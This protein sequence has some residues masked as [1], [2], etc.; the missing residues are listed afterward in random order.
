M[1][2]IIYLQPGLTTVVAS[3]PQYGIPVTLVGPDGTRAVFNNPS[4]PDYVGMLTNI[5]GMDSPEVRESAEDL[6]EED[7]GQHGDF[8]YGRRPIVVEGMVDNRPLGPLA[9]MSETVVRNNRM[10]RLQRATNALRSDAT[11]RWL[12][13]GGNEQ[14]VLVRR[15]QPLR[16]SGGWNKS[17]QLAL[18]SADYRIVSAALHETQFAPSASVLQ[19]LRNVGTTSTLPVLTVFGPATNPTFYNFSAGGAL[20]LNYALAAGHFIT[21]D[22]AEKTATLD[23]VTNIYSAVDFVNSQWWPMVPGDNSIRWNATGTTGSSSLRVNW[24]DAWV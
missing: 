13:D 18:V 22:F 9:G 4:D 7:G 14:M 2:D 6:V 21:L 19:S 15:Q 12:P 24:R 23:G 11:M 8:F 3:G 20:V 17:F 5:T 1:A 10:T 16:I